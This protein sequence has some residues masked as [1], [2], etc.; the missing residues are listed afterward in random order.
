MLPFT[1]I[2]QHSGKQYSTAVHWVWI[3]QT[4]QLVHSDYEVGAFR[5]EYNFKALSCEV[6]H[7]SPQFPCLSIE[8]FLLLTY[9]LNK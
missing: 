7:L 5:P 8:N 4:R 6:A 2:R 3:I 1:T 9:Q